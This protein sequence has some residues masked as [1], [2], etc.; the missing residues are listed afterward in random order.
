MAADYET[1]RTGY[2]IYNTIKRYRFMNESTGELF[3]RYPSAYQ[4]SGKVK[5]DTGYEFDYSHYHDEFNRGAC[6]LNADCPHGELC[7]PVKLNTPQGL[8]F[9]KKC[10]QRCQSNTDCPYPESCYGGYCVD[11]PNDPDTIDTTDPSRAQIECGNDTDCIQLSDNSN[12][13]RCLR[14]SNGS[15]CS[16]VPLTQQLPR[17][18]AQAQLIDD[19]VLTNSVYGRMY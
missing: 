8:K 3:N 6:Y 16:N 14:T 9:T 15:F 10:V 13:S 1:V 5:D 7:I 4:I 12:F 2:S 19:V 17:G 18:I 11:N